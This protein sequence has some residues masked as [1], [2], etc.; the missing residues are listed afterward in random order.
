MSQSALFKLHGP[1]DAFTTQLNM[2]ATR[3]LLACPF[4]TLLFDHGKPAIGIVSF[5]TP[6]I[7]G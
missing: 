5:H 7:L 2:S 6:F 4:K 1:L 3:G